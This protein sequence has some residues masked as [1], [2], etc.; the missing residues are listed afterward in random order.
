MIG[1]VVVVI[2]IIIIGALALGGGHGSTTTGQSTITGPSTIPGPSYSNPHPIKLT[3]PAEVPN[4]AQNFVITY[5]NMQVYVTGAGGSEWIPAQGNGDVDLMSLTNNSQVIGAMNVSP[6]ENIGAVRFNITSA[7]MKINGVAYGV[8]LQSPQVTAYMNLNS[9]VGPVSGVLVELEPVI[10]PTYSRSN[11]TYA[12]FPSAA[13]VVTNTNLGMQVGSIAPLTPSEQ[14][15]LY[16][17]ALDVASGGQ[18]WYNTLYNSATIS[19]TLKNNGEKNVHLQN[20]LIFGNITATAQPKGSLELGIP[21]LGPGASSQGNITIVNGVPVG[22]SINANTNA[23]LA[24]LVD[25]GILVGQSGVVP[26]HVNPSDSMQIIG[27]PTSTF[28][29]GYLVAPGASVTLTFEG[30]SYV[31]N[32]YLSIMPVNGDTYRIVVQGTNG[33]LASTTAV[34]SVVR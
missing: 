28:G 8:S 27:G 10:I 1:A 20:V 7:Y 6:G 2:V 5:T 13:A 26:L 31:G 32:G 19:V 33:T 14:S 25:V 12:L 30:P 21:N 16:A 17:I 22:F 34:A 24:S 23:T 11:V 4:G 15:M 18:V 9:T 3:D 29:G